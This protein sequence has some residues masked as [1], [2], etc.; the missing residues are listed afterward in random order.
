MGKHARTA[1]TYEEI[2]LNVSVVTGAC[3]RL[4]AGLALVSGIRKK[5]FGVHIFYT[6]AG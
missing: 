6:I 2:L 5:H 1:L 4:S 3:T